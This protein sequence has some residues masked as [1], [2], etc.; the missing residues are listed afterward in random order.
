[1][2]PMA[3]VARFVRQLSHD[4]RN[5]LNAA[6]LQAAYLKEI[7]EDKEAKTEIQRLRGMVSELGTSLQKLTTSI[8][9]VKLTC[10][11]YETSAFAEDLRHKTDTEF[12]EQAAD[13]EWQI[14]AGATMIEID[15][16]LL[17][18][19]MLELFANALRH[20]RG[21]GK[22]SVAATTSGGEFEV[23]LREPK[24]DFDL[25]TE[26]WGMEPF[27]S[28]KHGHYGLGLHRVRSIV[29]AHGGRLTARYDA[30]QSSLTTTVSLPVSG[31]S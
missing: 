7:V 20:S 5:H 3:D 1:M 26:A 15:P 25:P 10:M 19:A 21:A 24:S 23:R 28:V 2:V 29:E 13:F 8:A 31:Q 6:E 16:Q 18:Q 9:P 12:A 27:K 14:D 17:Q 30:Q 4:L 22:I 11:P